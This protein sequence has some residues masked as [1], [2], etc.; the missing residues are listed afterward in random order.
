MDD[1][2]FSFDEAI[3][4]WQLGERPI[5]ELLAAAVQALAAGADLPSLAQLAGMDGCSWSE[6][7]PLVRRVLAERRKPLPDREHALRTF[8]NA[9]TRRIVTG[10]IVPEQGARRLNLLAWQ[11]NGRPGHEDLW[12][13]ATHYVTL[14]LIDAGHAT[15][16]QLRREIINDAQALLDRGGVR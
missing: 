16:E 8:P 10:E 7:E 11:L 2:W 13:F 1:S 6:I 12:P 3:A 5:E 15:I 4:E 14:D 9:I